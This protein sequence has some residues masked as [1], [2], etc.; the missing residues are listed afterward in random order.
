MTGSFVRR[1]A[2]GSGRRLAALHCRYQSKPNNQ[3]QQTI[4]EG[5]P[6]L[7]CVQGEEGWSR[8]RRGR[9]PYAG[10]AGWKADLCRQSVAPGP[11]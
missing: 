7:E 8:P 5:L 10:R 4:S 9:L 3:E 6:G 2:R 11:D 1:Q